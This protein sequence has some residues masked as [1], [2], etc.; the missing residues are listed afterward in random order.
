MSHQLPS[1]PNLEHL[2]S[3]AKALLGALAQHL[4]ARG[5]KVKI[6]AAQIGHRPL[7]HNALPGAARA[8]VTPASESHAIFYPTIKMTA[9]P[10]TPMKSYEEKRK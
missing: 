6:I 4:V 10:S 7:S 9:G 8:K 3:Q 1:R 2:R 5:V